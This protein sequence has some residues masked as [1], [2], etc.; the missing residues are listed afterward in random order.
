MRYFI[1]TTERVWSK[2]GIS[3]RALEKELEIRF[4]RLEEQRLDEVAAGGDAVPPSSKAGISV[5]DSS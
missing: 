1:R 3:Q 5:A 4:Y 2:L